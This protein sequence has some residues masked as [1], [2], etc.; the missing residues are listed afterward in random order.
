[1]DRPRRSARK[2]VKYADEQTPLKPKQ[3]K[4]TATKENIEPTSTTATTTVTE[5][6]TAEATATPVTTIPATE[7]KKASKRGATKKTKAPR[8]S[9]AAKK[10]NVTVEVSDNVVEEVEIKETEVVK[11]ETT[12]SSASGNS[13]EEESLP[14]YLNPPIQ[15]APQPTPKVPTPKRNTSGKYQAEYSKTSRAG[16]RGHNCHSRTITKGSLRIGKQMHIE[17]GDFGGGMG[18]GWYH[19]ECFFRTH[20]H[21]MKWMDFNGVEDLS[22]EDQKMLYQKA[23]R[24]PMPAELLADVYVTHEAVQA[25]NKE[26][27]KRYEENRK[28]AAAQKQQE[29]AER[30]ESVKSSSAEDLI[31][32]NVS[33]LISKHT[34]DQLKVIVST[35]GLTVERG[36]VGKGG[37]KKGAPKKADYQDA[38]INAQPLC[39]I[40]SLVQRAIRKHIKVDELKILLEGAGLAKSGSKTELTKRLLGHLGGDFGEESEEET[41]KKKKNYYGLGGSDSDDD[42]GGFGGFSYRGYG[43]DC[44]ER[45]EKDS[46][47]VQKARY[48]DLEGVKEILR[49]TNR[50]IA[51]VNASRKWTEVQEKWGYD[52]SWEWHGETPLLAASKNGHVEVVYFLLTKEADPT[53]EACPSDDVYETPLKAVMKKISS[54][55]SNT[56]NSNIGSA[57]TFLTNMKKYQVIQKLL[58][59]AGQYWSTA[60]YSKSHYSDRRK[61]AFSSD[62]NKPRNLGQMLT[63]LSCV[64]RDF[65][66]SEEELTE[67]EAQIKEAREKETKR[68]AEELRKKIE[69]DTKLFQER[70]E[71]EKRAKEEREVREK[72]LKEEREVREKREKEEK[73]IREKQLREEQERIRREFQEKVRAAV[74]Q[75]QTMMQNRCTTVLQPI[76]VPVNMNNIQSQ[77]L[78]QTSKMN[79]SQTVTNPM[80]LADNGVYYEGKMVDWRHGTFGFIK[81]DSPCLAS[82]IFVHR[83]DI[84]ESWSCQNGSKLRF[85]LSKSIRKPGTVQAVKAT[86]L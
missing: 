2:P 12:L 63:A 33:K 27:E 70:V 42:Y 5:A 77:P 30:I 82:K 32:Q 76:P 50:P 41:K 74:G 54:M 65:S 29:N 85:Q 61:V 14:S 28:E 59:T 11:E 71:R 35:R 60:D 8:A 24:C 3:T 25:K 72:R 51:T 62:P 18:M 13:S 57:T 10:E 48:G 23:C 26:V 49:K 47:I 4:K 73:E 40:G 19:M 39:K 46:E 79:N 67:L 86:I 81:L 69:R 36:T 20:S 38:I 80:D 68:R 43:Y 21:T 9:K 53:L 1:M 84:T 58:H 75:Q 31:R 15:Q 52:K 34:V 55:S 6:T 56:T 37:K 22:V 64:S 16:C 78:S 45:D 17:Y 66:V 44:Y 7:T 83:S